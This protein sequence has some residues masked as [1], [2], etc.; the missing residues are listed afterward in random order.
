MRGRMAPPNRRPSR[1]SDAPSEESVPADST[2]IRSA[3]S[4]RR[5][6]PEEEDYGA[7]HWEIS[8][9]FSLAAAK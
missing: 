8:W 7:I 5:P 1:R 4:V 2:R 6:A 3:N 9:R